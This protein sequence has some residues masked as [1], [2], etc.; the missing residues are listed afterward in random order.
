MQDDAAE[1]LVLLD[2]QGDYYALPRRLV[3]RYRVPE[4]HRAAVELL[5]RRHLRRLRARPGPYTP[6]QD[7]SS[8]LRAAREQPVALGWF[9]VAEGGAAGP[10]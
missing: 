3:E 10:P 2:A 1:I 9:P 6:L 5:R 8:P 4:E 7:F